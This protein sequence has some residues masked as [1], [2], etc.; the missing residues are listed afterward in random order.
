[1]TARW[2]TPAFSADLDRIDRQFNAERRYGPLVVE[3]HYRGGKPQIAR[4][5]DFLVAPVVAETSFA[6][7][8]TS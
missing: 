7:A 3:I 5:R 2:L 4:V 6:T 8:S 1:M